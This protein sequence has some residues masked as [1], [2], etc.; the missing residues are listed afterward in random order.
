MQHTVNGVTTPY[1][2]H[3]NPLGDVVG[4]YNTSGTLVAKYIYDAWGNCTISGNT[5][6]A[7]AN[8]IRYRGY[9]YDDDTGLY[10][11]NAR[12]YS[13]LS[14]I[15]KIIRQK[16]GFLYIFT[17]KN[18]TFCPWKLLTFSNPCAIIRNRIVTFLQL[19]CNQEG[20]CMLRTKRLAARIALALLLVSILVQPAAA[21]A[22]TPASA[23]ESAEVAAPMK[24]PTVEIPPV[25]ET[26]A[27]AGRIVTNVYRYA[28]YTGTIIGCMENGTIVNVLGSSGQF[29]RISCFEIKGYIPKAQVAINDNGEYYVRIDADCPATKYL[30]TVS[31]DEAVALRNQ[32]RYTAKKYIG[33][34]YVWGGETPKGFDCSGFTQYVFRKNDYS[35]HRSALQQLQDGI[36]ISKE[37][38]QCGDL[39]FFTGTVHS[40]SYASHIGIYIGNGQMIHAGTYGI[41]VVD[42]SKA[43]YQNH[44]LCARRVILSDVEMESLLPSIGIT[45]NINSS[46]WRENTQTEIDGLGSFSAPGL[47]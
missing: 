26:P 11:C 6:I 40:G 20:L 30:P 39:I 16:G 19:C 5:A 42:F 34:P 33:V 35:L 3:R 17:R 27:P 43:Y 44:F 4:I 32:I 10:Y 22:L 41:A 8:P 47:A 1:Y 46:F 24:A 14:S 28:S 45:Q 15:C 21:I 25:Q 23:A 36:I 38:L 31:N 9:Y 13:H 7:K 12:Y 18:A 2:F 37:D 29:Y